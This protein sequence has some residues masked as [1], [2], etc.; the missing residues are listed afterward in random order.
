[1]AGDP[2]GRESRRLYSWHQVQTFDGPLPALEVA[3]GLVR[4]RTFDAESPDR[5]RARAAD[6]NAKGIHDAA[7]PLLEYVGRGHFGSMVNDDGDVDDQGPDNREDGPSVGR[8]VVAGWSA[9]SRNR[10]RAKIS[11]LDLAPIT[12]GDRLPVMV[13]LTLPGDWLA[14]TPTA[15]DASRIWARFRAAWAKRWGP[16]R[17]IWKREFQ[18]RGAP[19]WH[20]WLV[21]PV[22]PDEL[23]SEFIPWLSL[24]WTRALGLLPPCC[25]D[26]PCSVKDPSCH[27]KLR[28]G[29]CSCSE[30]C[31]SHGAGTGVDQAE[32]VRA[33]DPRRLQ[34]YFL[35][36]SLG[37]GKEYQNEPPPEWWGASVGR[38]WGVCG[39]EEAVACVDLD[40]RDYGVLWRAAARVRLANAMAPAPGS[41]PKSSGLPRVMLPAMRSARVER[42]DSRT[43]VVRTRSVRRRFRLYAGAGFILVNDGPAFAAQ[44]AKLADSRVELR[45]TRRPPA[46]VGFRG[47]LADRGLL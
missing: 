24:A 36:E 37:S 19:H 17:C 21:P 5:S 14:V 46:L 10:L 20:L 23:K 43:G 28:A 8:G 4:F 1:M 9:R 11:R 31:R 41:P 29:W 15:G 33:R 42:V 13:T 30:F 47:S 7:L 3:P 34:E 12:S 38:F 25:S 45:A 35:K 40:P 2:F 39:L 18:D 26:V 44:L 27:Q 32:G 22:A 6:L 16:L